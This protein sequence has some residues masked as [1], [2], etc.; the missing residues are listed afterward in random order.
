MV[1]KKKQNSF[2]PNKK[3]LKKFKKMQ[4][5][6]VV[7][8]YPYLEKIVVFYLVTFV[9]IIKSRCRRPKGSKGTPTV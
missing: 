1:F 7:V 5:L 9:K 4:I 3:I 2:Q 6:H 8:I